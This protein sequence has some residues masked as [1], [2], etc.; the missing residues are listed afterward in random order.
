MLGCTNAPCT[1]AEK[2]VRFL[3]Q[4]WQQLNPNLLDQDRVV[5]LRNEV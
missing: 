3:G 2:M 1:P 5:D 4:L